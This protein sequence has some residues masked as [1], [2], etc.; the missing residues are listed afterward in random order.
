MMS[1]NNK[2]STKDLSS[3]A[4]LLLALTLGSLVP[5]SWWL[6]IPASAATGDLI[7][8]VDVPADYECDDIGTSVAIAPGSLI[9]R[10]DLGFVLITSCRG[11]DPEDPTAS[12]LYI[13]DPSTTPATKV[14]T[15]TTSSTPPLGW[16]SMA[17]RGDNADLLGCGN[18]VDGSH[19]VYSIDIDA[20]NAIADG[21]A[22]FLFNAE[23][24]LDICDGSTWDVTDKTVFQS[25]DINDTINH[26]SQTG[27]LLG[28]FAAPEGCPNSG[29]AVGGNSLYAAC[30]GTLTIHELDKL[31]G[32]VISSI[33][34][35]GSRTEDLECDPYT[36]DVDV[37]WSKD[38]YDN[39][40]FAF[41]IPQ[42]TCGVAGGPGIEPDTCAD[43]S[44]T[45]D[46]DG[47]GLL[48]CWELN[49]I[50]ADASVDPNPDP[51]F[52]W[53]PSDAPDPN[54][55]D[56]YVEVDWMVNHA[57]YDPGADEDGE[58]STMGSTC[59]DGLDNGGGD[60]ADDDDPDCRG[61]LQ[62]VI[63]AFAA[64]GIQ[65]HV[66]V[67]EQ[68]IDT[69]NDNLAFPPFT[70]PPTGGE[71]DF[72]TVK[73]AKFGTE[74]ERGSADAAKI[75]NAKKKAFHYALF[76][77]ILKGHGGTSGWAEIDGNDIV[78]SLGHPKWG[79]INGHARGTAMQQQAAFMHELGHNLKLR[80]GGD[81]QEPVAG[82]AINQDVNCKPNYLSVMNY[83]FQAALMGSTLV[84]DPP[85]DYSGIELP[86]LDEVVDVGEA[87]VGLDESVGIG[88]SAGDR[89]AFSAPGPVTGPP[90]VADVDASGAINWNQ[91][92]S[93]SD[94]SVDLDIN[95]LRNEISRCD[96]H[97]DILSGYNDWE[98]LQYNFR[99]SSEFADGVHL[100]GY[101]V[102]EL[103]IEEL[104]ARS[105]DGDGDGV[106]D[107]VDN[108]AGEPNPGQEDADA[109]GIGDVCD[110]FEVPIDILKSKINARFPPTTN[111]S[112]KVAIIS[113]GDFDVIANVDQS[114]LRFGRTGDEESLFRCVFEP[115]DVNKDG[116][117]DLVCRF[118]I[119][120]SGLQPG[121][122]EGV[123][124]GN[125]IYGQPFEGR[126]QLI[127]K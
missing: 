10:A 37:M 79:T 88:G 52:L 67:D 98:N 20:N 12:T 104:A 123:L 118:G 38:A 44:N 21:T 99:N 64:Q 82:T 41:E 9:G 8:T 83:T 102:I 15:I 48:D 18:T 16:G 13:F 63:D 35:P 119:V 27:T 28:S 56:I 17:L 76:A 22:T 34:Y 115:E 113:A 45:D 114:S 73:Q 121:D 42:G 101:Q 58:T 74:S 2:H 95:N 33:S 126:D 14:K 68:A 11:E 29:L 71:P 1:K 127:V 69:H 61:V 122:T 89:T 77:H 3:G 97:G 57:P 6:A 19:P 106:V 50:P 87:R 40:V 24:G 39:T 72:D 53:D 84:S 26:F 25:P 31:T 90:I 125:T 85:L 116:L 112:V 80:H 108:C 75:L 7:K 120:D 5:T 94:N 46:T 23:P 111:R 92:G 4:L 81:Q 43:G 65:L 93:N 60:G 109:D 105:P 96:G 62:P 91:N 124:T 86:E 100:T 103:D 49:G 36:A 55:K 107:V 32:A 110:Q 54:I 47:D 70:D 78:V 51:D 66:L 117:D 30:N 59:T